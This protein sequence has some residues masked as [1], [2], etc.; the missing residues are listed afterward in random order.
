MSI[1]LKWEP[2]TNESSEAPSEMVSLPESPK[3]QSLPTYEKQKISKG[4]DWKG[5]THLK[6][7]FQRKFIMQGLICLFATWFQYQVFLWLSP[8]STHT[9]SSGSRSIAIVNRAVNRGESLTDDVLEFVTVSQSELL[10]YVILEDEISQYRNQRVQLPLEKNA[11]LFKGAFH[12]KD[13]D[14]TL[15]EKTP[16]GKRLLNIQ[17]ELAELGAHLSTGDFVEVKAFFNLPNQPQTMRTVLKRAP[18]AGIGKKFSEEI[19]N[20]DA[21]E[22]VWFY[23]TPEEWDFF[24]HAKQ[25]A[26]F[27]VV[28]I[29]P[30]EKPTS[31]DASEN[32]T[33]DSFMNSAVVKDIETNRLFQ[34]KKG[35]SKGNNKDAQ[36]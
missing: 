25:Y 3:K 24:F 19:K 18:I 17:T 34:I 29:N 21:Q 30:S 35:N 12:T 36:K 15:A 20:S 8:A 14:K 6:G 16:P 23:V 9:E 27:Y 33:V 5:N 2:I 26:K 10:D 7:L 13:H 11:V 22:T 1:S 28:P 32:Y 31:K 4:I